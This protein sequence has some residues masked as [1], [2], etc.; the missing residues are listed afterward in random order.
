MVAHSYVST[1]YK[2]FSAI[3]IL[4]RSFS[5]KETRDVDACLVF[6]DVVLILEKWSQRVRNSKSSLPAQ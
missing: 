6:M 4:I 3:S 5:E 1:N 2:K